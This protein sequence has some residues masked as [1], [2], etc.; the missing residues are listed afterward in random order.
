MKNEAITNS[1][2]KRICDH[3]NQDHVDSLSAYATFYG[4][5]K[6]PLEVKMLSLN[7]EYMNLDVDGVIV[8]IKFDHI[9]KDSNDAHQTLV[10]MI[11]KI[12]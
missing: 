7:Q 6:D 10:S 3:M 4:G 9:L 8:K 5:I 2:S 12:S 1:V 11:K